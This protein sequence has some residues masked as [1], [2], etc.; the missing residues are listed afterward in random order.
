MIGAAILIVIGILAGQFFPLKFREWVR[1]LAGKARGLVLGAAPAL[2]KAASSPS[3][4]A[5]IASDAAASPAE[6]GGASANGAIPAA[7]VRPTPPNKPIER[8]RFWT[9]VSAFGRG[10][11]N[12]IDFTLKHPVLLIG[13]VLVAFW[14][15]AGSSCARLPFGK[16][17]DALRMERELAEANA[18]VKEHEARLAELSRDLAVN[19]ERDRARRAAALAEAEQDISNAESQVDPDALYDAY[20]RGY[21][22][23]LDPGACP[24]GGDPAPRRVAPVRG[25][26]AGPV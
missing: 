8:H 1:A 25:A 21:L 16:S 4:A 2:Q 20:E 7:E 17:A 23:L 24:G 15:I 22:C 5:S 10:I 18:A 14:L 3:K 19:T 6:Y 26:V 11:A 9:V 13:L 12:V